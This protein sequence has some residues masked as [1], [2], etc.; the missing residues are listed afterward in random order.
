MLV[1]LIKTEKA[2]FA[3]FFFFFV[4]KLPL[5]SSDSA[6]IFHSAC[7]KVLFTVLILFNSVARF[8]DDPF[9]QE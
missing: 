2:G 5:L 7:G 1:I 8:S 9:L 4:G 3:F 6:A